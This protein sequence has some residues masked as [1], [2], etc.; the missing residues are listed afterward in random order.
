MFC[1]FCRFIKPARQGEWGQ[2]YIS[3]F[4]VTDKIQVTATQAECV[5]DSESC[6][7]TA[8]QRQCRERQ[9]FN[10]S[11]TKRG[12]SQ[13]VSYCSTS[14]SSRGCSRLS[15]SSCG[16]CGRNTRLQQVLN[17]AWQITSFRPDFRRSSNVVRAWWPWRGVHRR[18]CCILG[19]QKHEPSLAGFAT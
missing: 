16:F 19:V 15:N 1:V 2:C 4:A 11:W 5:C 12:S 10:K 18:M 6:C 17:P 14:S 8:L 9:D 7:S 13:S 3:C